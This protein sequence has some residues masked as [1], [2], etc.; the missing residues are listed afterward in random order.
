MLECNRVYWEYENKSWWRNKDHSWI[1]ET[2]GVRVCVPEYSRRGSSFKRDLETLVQLF[3]EHHK[4]DYVITM[5]GGIDS[6]VTAQ[7]FFNQGIKFRVL[8]LSLF[9]GMNRGDIIWAVKWCK[10]HDIEYKIV[11]LSY[12]EFMHDTIEDAIESGQFVRSPS[13][14]ALTHLFRYVT[15]YE[16]LIFSGHNPDFLDG[17]G[18]GWQEDSPNMVK[19]AINHRKRFFTFTSLEPIFCWYAANYDRTKAGN[20]NCGFIHKEY[21]EL[22]QRT[23]LTGW[24]YSTPYMQSIMDKINTINGDIPFEPFI[25]WDRFK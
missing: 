8:I 5:S 18:I 21:P 4:E 14:M 10:D 19:Y 3:H 6:E 13:Q 9:N 17:V 22:K 15:P 7:A 24:E 16:I 11:H 2:A 23:K 25:T 12:D 20:K 1:S